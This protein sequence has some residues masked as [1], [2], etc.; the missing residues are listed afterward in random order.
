MSYDADKDETQAVS[1]FLF[2]FKVG[3]FVIFNR[4]QSSIDNICR[5]NQ[6]LTDMVDSI[7]S[8]STYLYYQKEGS[9]DWCVYVYQRCL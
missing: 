1:N 8:S 3:S 9:Q 2:V 6:S 7:Q 5:L 4:L